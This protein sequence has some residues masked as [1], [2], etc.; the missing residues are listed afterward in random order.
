M[1]SPYF[2]PT[3]PILYAMRTAAQAGVDVRLML[4]AR[5]DSRLTEWAGRSYVQEALEGGVKICF[6]VAG[7]NHS[8]LLVCDDTLS[9]CGSTN[10]DFRSFENN[11]ESNVFFYDEAMAQRFKAIFLADEAEC[12]VL[13]EAEIF[14]RRPFLSR[15]WESLVR[16]LSPLL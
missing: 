15:L 4:P 11:F 3:E 7:F 1:Q 10:V 2:L 14:S 5:S 9:T 6:Y 8:K 16:L 13:D 12:I